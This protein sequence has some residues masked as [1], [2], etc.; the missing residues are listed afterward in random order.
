MNT[1][2][3]LRVLLRDYGYAVEGDLLICKGVRGYCSDRVM[4]KV[5]DLFDAAESLI[6][7]IADEGYSARFQRIAG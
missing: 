7:I 1:D 6:P 5:T 2:T 4:R 3:K